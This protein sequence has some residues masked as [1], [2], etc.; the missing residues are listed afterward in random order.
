MKIM[1]CIQND[2]V[3]NFNDVIIIA[4]CA[5]NIE[6]AHVAILTFEWI[7]YVTKSKKSMQLYFVVVKMP[8]LKDRDSNI[9]IIL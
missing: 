6:S 1:Q 7:L 5:L 9:A 3:F 8:G 2:V 4:S